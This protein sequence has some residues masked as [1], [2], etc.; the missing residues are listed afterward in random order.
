MVF[1]IFS[2]Q[3]HLNSTKL[4]NRNFGLGWPVGVS[5]TSAQG[6]DYRD[7]RVDDL[8]HHRR[9]SAQQFTHIMPL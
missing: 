2:D 6:T 7:E 3:R 5:E 9:Q 1:R 4:R 8:P